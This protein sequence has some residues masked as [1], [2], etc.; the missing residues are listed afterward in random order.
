MKQFSSHTSP[1]ARKARIVIQEQDLRAQVQE[2]VVN[3]AVKPPELLSV[4]PSGKIPALLTDELALF[5][6]RVICEYLDSLAPDSLF[7]GGSQM[8]RDKTRVALG[9][10]MMDAAV[11]LMLEKRRA[12]EQR[13]TWFAERE[14]SRIER[15]VGACEQGGESR[16]RPSVGDISIAC[17]LSYLDLRLPELEWRRLAPALDDWSEQLEARPAFAAT[18][19]G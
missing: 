17:A 4:N 15:I 2:V 6:S 8:W 10:A 1:Y 11:A 12:E 19:L 3:H 18:R 16:D 14:R 5:D 7:P 9:D 13:S